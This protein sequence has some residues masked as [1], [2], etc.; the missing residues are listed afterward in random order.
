MAQFSSG[1]QA[2][3]DS[4][5]N[6]QRDRW[7]EH[8]N[9]TSSMP[10]TSGTSGTSE[11]FSGRS[12]SHLSRCSS[13]SIL[14][15]ED[16]DEDFEALTRTLKKATVP[17]LID[18]CV[19]GEEALDYLNQRGDYC[20]PGAAARPSLILLDL[21]LPGTDGRDVL[22]NIKQTEALK[23][24]PVVILTTSSN[25]RDVQ[26]CYRYGV[27]SYLLKPMSLSRFQQVIQ[28]LVE[29]WFGIVLLPDD[30]SQA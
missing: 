8:R 2:S 23:T 16:S 11:P 17:C 9:G 10:D 20:E 3:S 24:I 1:L 5:R 26:T 14:V 22:V 28:T 13:P 29:Y 7:G 27:N 18:R 6:S 30:D 21:N 19:D 12:S 25:P 15:I 4:G